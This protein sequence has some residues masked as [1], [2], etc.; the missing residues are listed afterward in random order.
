MTS[1]CVIHYIV[2]MHQ[3]CSKYRLFIAWGGIVITVMAADVTDRKSW[4]NETSTFSYGKCLV[5][6]CVKMK[7]KKRLQTSVRRF[8][9]C[10]SFNPKIQ[11]WLQA[12]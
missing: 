11:N 1:L 9:I 12:E 6:K 10:P 7:W 4:F 2:I 3:L 8:E 5:I